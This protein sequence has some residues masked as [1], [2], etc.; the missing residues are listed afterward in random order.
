MRGLK[1]DETA[2]VIVHGHMFMQN[3][4][5]VHYELGIEARAHRRVAAAFNELRPS[6]LNGTDPARPCTASTDST[7]QIP[8]GPDSR[9][10]SSRLRAE[11]V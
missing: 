2:R 4:R 8:P 7:Q 10:A 9:Y 11:L 5:R 3:V 1:R 6:Y